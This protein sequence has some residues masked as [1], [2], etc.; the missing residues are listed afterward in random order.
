M[1]REHLEE[2]IRED[3]T[4][5]ITAAILRKAKLTERVERAMEKRAERID[6]TCS[7]LAD[8]VREDFKSDPS[9]RWTEPVE[10]IAGELASPLPR[11]DD[12][13]P[14]GST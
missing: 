1:L 7:M 2:S 3:L 12:D 8:R 13:A 4:R 14:V 5:R 6:E 10:R 11:R 9:Q